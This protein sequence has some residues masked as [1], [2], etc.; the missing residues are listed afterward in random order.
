M[1]PVSMIVTALALG[2]AA[3]LKATAAAAVHDGYEGLKGL[4][5]R[6]FAQIDVKPLEQR[7]ESQA[8]RDSLAEDLTACGADKDVELLRSAQALLQLIQDQKP[9]VAPAIG[10][11]LERVRAATAIR[12]EDIVAAGTGV[13]GED[14]QTEGSLEIKGVRAGIP[15]GQDPNS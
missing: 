15:E 13:K 8:K 14:W 12:I 1:D 5:Q 4:L 11:D 6:R 10:I 3:G 9:E 2:A 7:P